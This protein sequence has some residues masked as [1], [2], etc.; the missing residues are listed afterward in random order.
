M[1][2]TLLLSLAYAGNPLLVET[3]DAAPASTG[4]NVINGAQ[5]GLGAESRVLVEDGAL[6][7]RVAPTDQQF[8][9]VQRTVAL[10]GAS[11][12]KVSAR[13]RTESVDPVPAKYDNCQVYVQFPGGKV[14]PI[15]PLWG[16]KP[17]ASQE[18]VFT[19]PPGVTEVSVGVFLSMP[20]AAWFDDLRV[21]A[22]E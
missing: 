17:W 1:L 15:E 5:V 3:F 9:A 13:M 8:K 18:R 14:Q 6:V 21:E 11:K 20:G 12:I 22:V 16:T 19:V 4:W 10:G 7:L 2:P